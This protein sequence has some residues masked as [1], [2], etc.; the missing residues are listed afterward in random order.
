MPDYS[1][2][3]CKKTFDKKSNYINHL[4]RKTSCIKNSLTCINCNKIFTRPRTLKFHMVKCLYP[5]KSTEYQC[6]FCNQYFSTKYTLT[7][8]ENNTCKMKKTYDEYNKEDIVEMLCKIN[9]KKTA[10]N[11]N[12]TNNINNV[13]IDNRVVNNNHTINNIDNS[14]K[15]IVINNFGHEN[16][17]YLTDVD[18][19]AIMNEGYM[20]PIKYTEKVH[21]N[22]DH[23]ENHNL[24]MKHLGGKFMDVREGNKWR[25][26]KVIDVIESIVNEVDEI[27]CIKYKDL[28]ERMTQPA[29]NRAN[30]FMEFD[31]NENDEMK[32]KYRLIIDKLKL[33]MHNNRDIFILPIHD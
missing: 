5:V 20:A 19:M 21:F 2:N 32:R 23:P 4:N 26:K 27:I 13:N 33:C 1:C 16:L 31:Y 6:R 8:H 14:Q 30:K 9:N 24:I 3:K 29:K 17:S 28:N 7:R 15:T 25:K 18:W 12:I 10:K 22:K 11:K